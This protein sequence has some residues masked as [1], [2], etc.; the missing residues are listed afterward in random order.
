MWKIAIRVI[1]IPAS[2]C[3]K[4]ML[5]GSSITKPVFSRIT[6]INP[7]IAE[8]KKVISKRTFQILRWSITL[9]IFFLERAKLVP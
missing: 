4:S 7:R 6:R 9:I 5:N 8:A 3:Q 1:A 2:T